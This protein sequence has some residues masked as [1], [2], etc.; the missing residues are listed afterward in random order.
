MIITFKA[1]IEGFRGKVCLKDGFYVRK[2]YGQYVLQRCPT[3][4]NHVKT[5]QEHANQ[6][7]F[8]Q[9]YKRKKHSTE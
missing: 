1:P 3:R 5:P 9:Q 2:L 4:T 8:I 7:R 6:Q